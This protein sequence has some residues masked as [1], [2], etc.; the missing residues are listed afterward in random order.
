MDA[1]NI[2]QLKKLKATLLRLAAKEAKHIGDDLT[3]YQGMEKGMWLG[4]K[5]SAHRLD[6]VIKEMENEGSRSST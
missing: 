4:Y 3:H 5:D 6:K 2:N 1:A